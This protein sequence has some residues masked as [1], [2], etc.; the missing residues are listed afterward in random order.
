M[1]HRPGQSHRL[2]QLCS[3]D[4]AAAA[5]RPGSTV[6][7]PWGAFE[8]HGPHLPLGTDALF[9]DRLLD[10]VLECLPADLPIW[11]LPLQSLGFSPEHQSFAGTLSLPADILI[12]Q[13]EAV[14]RQL[15]AAGFRRLL[16]FNAHGGQIA[17]LQ[18]AARQLRA[19]VPQLAVL[20]CFLWSG[21]P[22]LAGLIPEP[23]RSQGLHA[24]LAETSLMLHLQ[25]ELVGRLPPADGDRGG[26]PPPGWSLEGALP[27]AWLTRDLSASG[28]IGDPSEANAALGAR[29][30]TC[31]VEG[32]C[33]LLQDLLASDWPQPF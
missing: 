29:L 28:V 1:V 6:I 15:S 27:T 16:L 7:W 9:A 2:E 18:V 24:G 23:E 5:A 19:A 21:V 12:T 33:R 32:W 4:L 8:Q 31:L 30:A 13:V 3:A 26:T 22:G 25:P 14:G 17:L 10:Q 20:P 11:R